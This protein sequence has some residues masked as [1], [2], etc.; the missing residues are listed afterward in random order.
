MDSSYFYKLKSYRKNYPLILSPADSEYKDQ[1]LD[2]GYLV[3]LSNIDFAISRLVLSL[4]RGIEHVAK[5][6]INRLF[7]NNPDENTAAKCV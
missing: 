7:M 5:A 1:R 4:S 3:V 6:W 2:F